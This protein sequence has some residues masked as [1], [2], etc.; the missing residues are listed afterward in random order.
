MSVVMLK[1][2][3]IGSRDEQSRKTSQDAADARV[4]RAGANMDQGNPSEEAT[5]QSRD[6]TLP[7]RSHEFACSGR[8]EGQH[9]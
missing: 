8:D 6:E 4:M 5:R 9:G 3:F 2:F 1:F 7:A